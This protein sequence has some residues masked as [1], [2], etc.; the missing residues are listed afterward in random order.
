MKSTGRVESEAAGVRKPARTVIPVPACG[1]TTSEENLP[2][3]AAA[4]V[5]TAIELLIR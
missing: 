3:P 5:S 4:A 2:P 1:G